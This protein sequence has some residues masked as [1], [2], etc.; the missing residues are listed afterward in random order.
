[1]VNHQHLEFFAVVNVMSV[2]MVSFSLLY[3]LF[4]VIFIHLLTC[5]YIFAMSTLVCCSLLDL[6]FLHDA[7]T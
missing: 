2:S 5:F 6:S 1:M 4:G 3:H 7:F